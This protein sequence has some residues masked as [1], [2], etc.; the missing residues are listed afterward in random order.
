MRA[1][2]ELIKRLFWLYAFPGTPRRNAKHKVGRTGDA[3]PER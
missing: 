3:V 2:T 1:R